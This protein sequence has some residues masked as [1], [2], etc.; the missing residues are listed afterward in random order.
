MTERESE[1]SRFFVFLG[2]IEGQ[3]QQRQQS[4]LWRC[5][6]KLGYQRETSVRA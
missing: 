4:S 5:C 1:F 2:K 3:Q 6:G